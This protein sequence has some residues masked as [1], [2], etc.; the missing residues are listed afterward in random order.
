M[1]GK[2]DETIF[3]AASKIQG[4]KLIFTGFTGADRKEHTE[5]SYIKPEVFDILMAN[6]FVRWDGLWLQHPQLWPIFFQRYSE[7]RCG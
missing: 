4:N 1:T 6:G 2:N 7:G 5:M 3:T